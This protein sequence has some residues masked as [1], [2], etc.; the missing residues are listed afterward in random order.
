[1]TIAAISTTRGSS[2]A[3]DR[4]PENIVDHGWNSDRARGWGGQRQFAGPT[5]KHH[6]GWPE[7]EPGDRKSA[8][9]DHGDYGRCPR[10]ELDPERRGPE[11]RGAGPGRRRERRLQLRPD[12][13]RHWPQLPA[14]RW[15][16]GVGFAAPER[17]FHPEPAVIEPWLPGPRSPRG[18]AWAA[19]H[20]LRPELGRRHA[21][22]HHRAAAPRRGQGLRG[23]RVRFADPHT[24]A[25]RH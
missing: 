16:A 11:W 1:M 9:G 2:N 22:R 4:E 20:R 8:G 6:R 13:P 7:G 19:G 10:A 24:C 21:E 5:R 3:P 14:G 15:L 12:D 18:A 17:I 25:H 23:C